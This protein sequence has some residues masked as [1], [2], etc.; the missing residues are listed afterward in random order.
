MEV[1]PLETRPSPAWQSTRLVL[2]DDCGTATRCEAMKSGITQHP[3]WCA[4]GPNGERL[5]RL[6]AAGE[7]GPV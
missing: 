4:Q 5:V 7:V 3:T 2:L 1:N 6:V